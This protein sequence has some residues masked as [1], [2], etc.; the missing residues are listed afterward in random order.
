M[1]TKT[2]NSVAQ[3]IAA[4]HSAPD[5]YLAKVTP[6]SDKFARIVGTIRAS[7]SA[8]QLL[9]AVR[10]LHTRF[11]PVRG[12]FA[13]IA[14]NGLTVT[15]EGIIG[16]LPERIVMTPE[17]EGSYKAIAS[18]MYMDNEE[19]LWSMVKTDA[20]NILISSHA[21]DESEVMAN[22]M[23]S[24]AS[25][26]AAG[27]VQQRMSA[28]DAS[29]ASI[30]GGDL[31]TFV[32]QAGAVQMGFVVAAVA[33]ADGSDAGLSVVTQLTEDVHA[34]DRNMVVAFVKANDMDSDEAASLEAV[35]AGNINMDMIAN[36]YR[37]HFAR[38]PEYFEAFMERFRK[39]AFA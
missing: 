30:E 35:A 25:S 29:R 16:A 3:V 28:T 2:Q 27:D 21:S 9:S 4:V 7:A 33:N 34:V 38:R 37:R 1:Q 12:S 15:Y 36:Y 23:K 11:S 22:L 20:G 31:V 17:N 32:S 39:H 6:I 5:I 8:D 14:S 13:A 26:S 18:N 10:N 19:K 24:V